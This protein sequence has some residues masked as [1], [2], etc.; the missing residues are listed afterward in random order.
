L[1]LRC[2]CDQLSDGA[3][4]IGVLKCP[5]AILF[6][7]AEP[8]SDVNINTK[9]PAATP[10]Y[11]V[12]QQIASFDYYRTITS[13]SGP[14]N[15]ERSL[16]YRIDASYENAGSFQDFGYNRNLLFASRIKCNIASNT[17]VSLEIKY[18]DN[19]FWQ[20]YGFTPLV[21][22]APL[23]QEHSLNYGDRSPMHQETLFSAPG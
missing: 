19:N 5:G 2:A 6:G 18:S 9:Q 1:G 17:I 7:A 16:L 11:S 22:G 13:A 23:H 8:G 21:H 20:L 12:E 15:T 4:R 14:L 3:G 10:R